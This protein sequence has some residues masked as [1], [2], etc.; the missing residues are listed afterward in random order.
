MIF[1]ISLL[2]LTSCLTLIIINY[3]QVKSIYWTKLGFTYLGNETAGNI[4]INMLI[5]KESSADVDMKIYKKAKELKKPIVGSME[6][7]KPVV[8]ITDLDLLKNIL[9]K[10]FDNFMNRRS[11][12]LEKT[13]PVIHKML[14]FLENERWKELRFKLNPIFTAAKIRSMFEIFHSSSLKLVNFTEKSCREN[15]GV[16]DFTEGYQRYTMDVIASAA[17]G[18]DSG[19]FTEENPIFKKMGNKMITLSPRL[20]LAFI[21]KN[22]FPKLATGITKFQTITC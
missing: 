2:I 13:D 7:N 18:V 6:F 16:V 9:I 20:A 1:S 15:N 17:F 19:M 5:T 21:L 12:Q 4:L 10:D 14:F 3:F 22:S 11:L 8:F